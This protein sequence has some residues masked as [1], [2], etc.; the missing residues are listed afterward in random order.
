MH[1]WTGVCGGENLPSSAAKYFP[2]LKSILKYPSLGTLTLES[3][4]W[5]CS[6]K[7]LAASW[8][9]SRASPPIYEEN[10]VLLSILTCLNS[11]STICLDSLVF[12]SKYLI[13]LRKQKYK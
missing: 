5:H 11:Y 7:Y 3:S 8:N 1:D 12:G 13:D 6:L 2:L 9:F 4:T 10:W